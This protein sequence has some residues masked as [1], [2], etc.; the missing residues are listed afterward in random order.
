MS[1]HRTG[2]LA[3]WH[4]GGGIESH[5]GPITRTRGQELLQ[6]Y[7]DEVLAGFDRGDPAAVIFCVRTSLDLAEAML[8]AD[9]WQAAADARKF[10]R[11]TKLR[12]YG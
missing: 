6:F 8:A 7:A 5:L 3:Y 2:P 10:A 11:H 12:R 9:A 4:S 1:P